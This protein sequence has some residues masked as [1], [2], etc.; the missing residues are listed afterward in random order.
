MAVYFCLPTKDSHTIEGGLS[1]CLETANQ[2]ISEGKDSSIAIK[3]A[4]ARHGEP[5]AHIVLEVTRDGI[6]QV[7]RGRLVKVKTLR[8]ESRG[9]VC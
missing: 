1:T 7:R 9:Q 4:R 3:V 5:Y 2:L 6:R 8:D